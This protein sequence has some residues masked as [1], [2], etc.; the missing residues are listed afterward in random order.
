MTQKQR[1]LFITN[2]HGEDAVARKIAGFLTP[3]ETTL[4]SLVKDLPSGG[5]AL[6]NLSYLIADLRAGLLASFW[7]NLQFLTKNKNQFG[8]VVAVG[9]SVPLLI[10]RLVRAPLIFVGVNKSSYYHSFGFNYT[11]PEKILLKQLAKITFTRD[12]ITKDD[13]VKHNI[14][15]QFAGN[16]LM[17]TI[18]FSSPL[19][20]APTSS[21]AAA[22]VITLLPGSHADAHQNLSDLTSVAEALVQL[23]PGKQFMFYVPLPSAIHEKLSKVKTFPPYIKLL[24]GHFGAALNVA[25]LVIGLSGTAN[26]QAAG[27]GKPVVAFAGKGSQYTQKF[28]HAQKQLLGEALL[29]VTKSSAAASVTHLMDNPA[30]MKKMK[31]AGK[32]RMTQSNACQKIAQYIANEIKK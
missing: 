3:N 6:R 22:V 32:T 1:I 11:W 7:H 24:S 25:T 21:G 17:D 13:L 26:E 12:Q 27:L 15:A 10:S 30:Q 2:G 18:D 16:P 23:N 8:L 9:D 29:L 20:P 28:A 4:L 5:F 14:H 19:P 31:E